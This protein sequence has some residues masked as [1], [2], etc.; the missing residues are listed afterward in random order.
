VVYRLLTDLD[1]ACRKSGLKVIEVPGWK[2]R[3]RPGQFFPRGVVAHHTG[4]EGGGMGV[5]GG[6]LTQGRPGLNGPLCQLGLGRNGEVYVIAAGRANH[7]GLVRRVNFLAAG[8]GNTQSLGIEAMLSGSEPWPGSMEDDYHR[9]VAALCDYYG[10]PRTNVVSHA[11]CSTAGKWDP[12]VN[13]KTIDMAAFRRAVKA[14][15]STKEKQ[16]TPKQ[17]AMLRVVYNAVKNGKKGVR[18]DGEVT[19]IVKSIDR[20]LSALEKKVG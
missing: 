14:V 20:R 16:M 7:A 9:L 13:G 5:A 15:T 4:S 11:E 2:N 10:W 12:G 17:D 6:I 1:V 3:G 18:T 8:D 19:R